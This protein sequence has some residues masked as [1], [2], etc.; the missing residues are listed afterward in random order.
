MRLA[1]ALLEMLALIDKR[2]VRKNVIKYNWYEALKHI[3]N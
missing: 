3:F 1:I 2:E